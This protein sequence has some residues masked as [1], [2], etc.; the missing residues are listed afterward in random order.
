MSKLWFVVLKYS[1]VECLEWRPGWSFRSSSGHWS[2][3]FNSSHHISICTRPPAPASHHSHIPY[4]LNW[5]W[6][7]LRNVSMLHVTYYMI[8]FITVPL[9]EKRPQPMLAHCLE[10][11][12][13]N[14]VKKLPSYTSGNIIQTIMCPHSFS[15]PTS[16]KI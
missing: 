4:E 15:S 8:P 14:W 12:K 2:E 1:L 13:L 6:S 10:I 3:L 16:T 5:G 11:S 7:K 9:W